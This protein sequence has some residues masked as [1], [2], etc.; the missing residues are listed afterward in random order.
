M[1]VL[2]YHDVAI[3]IND[4]QEI[5]ISVW[6]IIIPYKSQSNFSASV[7]EAMEIL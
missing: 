1:R 6:L 2:L 4:I 5:F 3:S 7:L